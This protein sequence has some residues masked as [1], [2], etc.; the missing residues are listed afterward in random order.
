MWKGLVMNG[1][2]DDAVC[3]TACGLA[4]ALGDDVATVA[5][6]AR[7]GVIRAREL[8]LRIGSLETG[9]PEPVIGHPLAWLTA[10][11]EGKARLVRIAQAA[12]LDL[13]RSV[14]FNVWRSERTGFYLSLPDPNREWTGTALIAD[15]QV[16]AAREAAAAEHVSHETFEGI[17]DLAMRLNEW[18]TSPLIRFVSNVGQAAGPE[19]FAAAVRD[20]KSGRVRS[21]I[22]GSVDSLLDESTLVWLQVTERLKRDGVPTGLSPGEA[23]AFLLL[24]TTEVAA[25]R[26]ATPMAE[27]VTV[28]TG[29]E[30]R[31]ILSGEPCLG[32]GL[33]TTLRAVASE[34]GWQNRTPAWVV[35]DHNGEVPRAREW[36]YALVR[37][38]PSYPGLEAPIM[39]YPAVSLG[40]TAGSSTLVAACLV[41]TAFRRRYAPSPTATIVATSDGPTRGAVVLR[42]A[43]HGS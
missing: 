11:F 9:A 22:V 33:A 38:L 35:T 26:R 18:T 1:G 32:D 3:V 4:A 34:A 40:D 16:R 41:T 19:A 15:E 6:A 39:W 10:G 17:L 12:L 27:V 13:A 29:S 36:G 20:L 8:P 24:E 7:A 42:A 21:A 37:L 43:E 25:A 23:G 2:S 28:A 31:S 30:A 14:P 5:S